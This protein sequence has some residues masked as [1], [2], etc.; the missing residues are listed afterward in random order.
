MKYGGAGTDADVNATM[1]CMATAAME[2]VNVGSRYACEPALVSVIIQ[3]MFPKFQ[4]TND[5]LVFVSWLF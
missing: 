5:I 3:K 1:K 2:Q 4:Q